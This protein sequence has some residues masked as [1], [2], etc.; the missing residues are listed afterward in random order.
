M[1]DRPPRLLAQQARDPSALRWRPGLLAGA[2]TPVFVVLITL[3]SN[4]PSVRFLQGQDYR[5]PDSV[6]DAVSGIGTT[7]GS[8]LGPTGVSLS[9]PATSVVAGAKAG[10]REI[11][12]R[13]VY[14]AAGAALAVGLLAGIAADVADIIPLLL[15]LAGLAVVDVFTDAVVRIVQGPL[16]LGPLF[17]FVIVISD[18]SLLGLGSFFWTLVIGTGVS[19]LLEQDGLYALRAEAGH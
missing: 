10:A 13:A 6:V 9:L 1:P 16:L 18:L 2:A 4:L 11:R 17:T 12:H 7:L 3:Q 19:L 15:A 5:P 8:L 14:V